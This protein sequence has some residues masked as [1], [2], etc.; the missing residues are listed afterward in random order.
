M[1][2]LTGSFCWEEKLIWKGPTAEREREGRGDGTR[3]TEEAIRGSCVTT[4]IN[5]IILVPL[6]PNKKI[7]TRKRKLTKIVIMSAQTPLTAINYQ[8]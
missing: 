7:N 6:Q 2:L 1:I 5:K 8:K 3:E 4:Q